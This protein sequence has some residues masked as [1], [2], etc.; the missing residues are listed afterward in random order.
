MHFQYEKPISLKFNDMSYNIS[1]RIDE[2]QKKISNSEVIIT[3][4][5]TEQLLGEYRAFCEGDSVWYLGDDAFPSLIWAG[6]LDKDGKLDFLMDLTNHYNASK[7]TLFLSS[8]AIN[9]EIVRKVAVFTIVG[10]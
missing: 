1:V 2:P 8:H 5:G 7:I 3:K 10:C 6:D 4:D 9:E